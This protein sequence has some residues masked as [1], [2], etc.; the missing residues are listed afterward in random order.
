ML[1]GKFS[2]LIISLFCQEFTVDAS[3]RPDTVIII[4]NHFHSMIP[5]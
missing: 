5:Y 4:I 3:Q 2:A 1:I